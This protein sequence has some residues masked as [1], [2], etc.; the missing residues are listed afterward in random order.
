M[1][2]EKIESPVESWVE[3]GI[4]YPDEKLMM[5]DEYTVLVYNKNAFPEIREGFLILRLMGDGDKRILAV[6]TTTEEAAELLNS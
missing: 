6:E 4:K 5:A 1:V 3:L 2:E